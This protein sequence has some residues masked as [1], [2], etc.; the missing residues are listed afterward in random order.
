MIEYSIVT[1]LVAGAL[2]VGPFVKVPNPSGGGHTTMFALMMEAYQ[3][4]NNSYYFAL[5]APMP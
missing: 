5:C 3:I 4:Y 1:W 2:F